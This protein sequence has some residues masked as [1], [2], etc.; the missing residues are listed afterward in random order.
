MSW[1]SVRCVF[2][3]IPQGSYEE[4][5]TVWNCESFEAAIANAE[6]EANDYVTSVDESMGFTIKFTGLSQAY[7]L[8]ES[9]EDGAEVFSLLRDSTLTPDD[10]ISKFFDTG[11]ERQASE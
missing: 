10:Y 8:P 2:H 9:P 7:L 5:V 6:R 3:W 1:Y 4:R 11:E